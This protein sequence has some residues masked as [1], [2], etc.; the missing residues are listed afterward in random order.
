MADLRFPENL[1]GNSDPWIVFTTQTAQYTRRNRSIGDIN[2][3]SGGNSVALYFPTGFAVSDSLNYE[4]FEE[5]L[6]GFAAN[7]MLAGGAKAEDVLGQDFTSVAGSAASQALRSIPLGVGAVVARSQRKV[8][9]PREFMMF[10]N[11]SIREFSF[12]FTMIPQS[13]TEAQAIPEIIK[14]FRRA[15][16]PVERV[17][18]Y[19]F[20]DTFNVSYRQVDSGVIKLPE[21]ACTSIGVTYNPN[22][23]SFFRN[24][25][26]PVETNLEL[27]FTELRPINRALVESGY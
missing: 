10:S 11:P 7:K 23:I 26:I 4:S 20:P 14:F 5:G 12:S 3:N 22:S 21:I 19:I 17:L 6:G 25:G 24:N 18:D 15:A 1:D 13:E 8:T 9:N 27:S 16:Y 2:F